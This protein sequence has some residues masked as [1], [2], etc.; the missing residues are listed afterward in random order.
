MQISKILNDYII[1]TKTDYAIMIDGEWGAGKSWYWSN[2]LSKDIA[3]IKTPD[4]TN[5]DP[6]FFKAV[7]ISLF[8][9]STPEDLRSRIFEETTEI[10][11]NKYVKTGTKLIGF[12]ANMVANFFSVGDVKRQDVADLFSELSIDLSRYVLCFDDLER[13]KPSILLELL[14]YINTLIEQ[15]N[16]KVVFICNEDELKEPDYHKY[17]EK[18]VRFTHTIRADIR[19]MVVEFA[20]K[21]KNTTYSEYL[22]KYSNYIASVYAKGECNN[23]RTL[24]FNIDIFERVFDIVR[25]TIQPY[26]EHHVAEITNYMLLLSMLYSIE[27][28]R[29]ND[30]RKLRSLSSITRSWSYRIDT[31]ESLE[32]SDST[33]QNQ[34]KDKPQD[35][36]LEYQQ[37]VRQRYFCNTYIYGSSEALIDYLLTGFLDESKLRKEILAIDKESQRYVTSEEKQLFEALSQFWDTNDVE[38]AKAVNRTL[39]RVAEASFLLV[40]YPTFFLCLQ[41]LQN[42]EFIDLG[43]PIATLQQMFA[44][45]IDR[46]N[47]TSY[48]EDIN[49]YYYNNQEISTPE[50]TALVN[51]VKDKNAALYSTLSLTKFE[52]IVRDVKS[53]EQ[54]K[55]Y[56][57]LVSNIFQQ[58]SADE[59]FSL[60]L[61]YNNNRKRDFWNFFDERYN[62]RECYFVDIEFIIQLKAILKDYTTNPSTPIT[63]SRKYCCKIL[64]LLDNKTHQHEPTPFVEV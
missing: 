42:F 38:M 12:G 25:T 20:N 9:I 49:G 3:K 21:H 13:I 7:T 44:D 53:I 34:P 35:E 1:A 5:D 46:Y 15:D 22:K 58:I 24:K 62:F 10:F 54:L 4:S 2:V 61:Q 40:D 27:Y 11:K 32:S 19:E 39:E 14:G 51:R 36:I 60:F 28:R 31:L 59:F 57:G 56:Q 23:L 52:T 55:P 33:R 64:E 30:E 45:A 29:D 6:K 17:K 41:R 47:Q 8:G 43:M 26:E 16:V 37:S 18:V 63:G 48:I 50:Y